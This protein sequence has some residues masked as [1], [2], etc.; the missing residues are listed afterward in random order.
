M[1]TETWKTQGLKTDEGVEAASERERDRQTDIGRE[2]DRD[3]E[4]ASPGKP[5][6]QW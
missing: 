6:A 1:E 4:N 3:R 2:M 5:G